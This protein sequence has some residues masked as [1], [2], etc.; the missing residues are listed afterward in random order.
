M[1]DT[2]PTELLEK[3]LKEA[4][5]DRR[6]Q[7]PWRVIGTLILDLTIALL[8]EEIARRESAER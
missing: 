8:S 3:L 5:F 6:V 2:L 1:M 7:D 4:R